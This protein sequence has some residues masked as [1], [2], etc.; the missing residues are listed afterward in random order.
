[1]NWQQLRLQSDPTTPRAGVAGDG[2]PWRCAK[3][4][5]AVRSAVDSLW[6]PYLQAYQ[7][8]SLCAVQVDLEKYFEIYEISQMDIEDTATGA[9]PQVSEPDSRNALHELK[10]DYCKIQIL[11]RMLLCAL[12]A[13][14]AEECTSN[15]SKWSLAIE[16]METMISITSRSAVQVREAISTEEGSQH[17]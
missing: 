15:V 4:R 6:E 13:L 12:L 7:Y 11:R 8:L 5:R 2:P 9:T 10:A 17:A 14:G 1:M 3:L 16:H